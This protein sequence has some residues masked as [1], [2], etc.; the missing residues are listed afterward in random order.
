MPVTGVTRFERFFRAAAGLDV[1]RNDVKRYQDFVH[2]K[3]YDLLIIGQAVA[4]ANSRDIMEFRDL[5]ITKGLQESMHRFRRIDAEIELTPILEYLA[6]RPPLDVT[7]GEETED[8]LT[9]VIGGL[10]MA[11]AQTFTIIDPES[12]NVRSGDWDKAFG[13]FGL[14]L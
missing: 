13:I 9:E 7:L 6:S 11:L 5:P 10:S 14:L 1:D 12:R 8:R 3:L 4:K 2:G